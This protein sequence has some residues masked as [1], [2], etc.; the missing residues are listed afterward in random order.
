MTV[1]D[2]YC[3]SIGYLATAPASTPAQTTQG[4]I[5]TTTVYVTKASSGVSLRLTFVG[6]GMILMV[7]STLFSGILV[8][9]FPS[10]RS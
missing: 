8:Q 1:Y 6:W 2:G 3:T 7:L 5:A 10:F 4:P 9:A